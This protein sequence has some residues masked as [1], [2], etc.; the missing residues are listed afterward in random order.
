MTSL[1]NITHT[2]D[3]QN[4]VIKPTHPH[5]FC[6]HLNSHLIWGCPPELH[7]WSALLEAD[8]ISQALPKNVSENQ[9]IYVLTFVQFCHS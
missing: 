6:S 9:N 5:D 2:T 8:I 7:P 1:L 3:W 4:K